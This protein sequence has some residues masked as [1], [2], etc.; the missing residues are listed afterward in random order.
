MFAPAGIAGLLTAFEGGEPFVVHG[1][2]ARF[3]P[4]L[5]ESPLRS[6]EDVCAAYRGR[7]LHGRREGG[8]RFHL[9]ERGAPAELLAGGEALYLPDIADVVPAAS[10]WLRELEL[11][12]GIPSG[13][14]RATAWVAPAGE[15]TAL[16]FDAEDV[17]SIQLSGSKRFE[18]GEPVALGNAASYQFGPGIPAAADLYPQ[19]AAGFPDAAAA[20]FTTLAMQPGS[21][22][23]L[24]RGHWHR[25]HC[26]TPSLSISVV[27]SPP[28]L[29][30]W[31]LGVLR[32][33]ALE[34]PRWRAPL[35]GAPQ[36]AEKVAMAKKA[37]R[38]LRIS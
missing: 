10:S 8:A 19:C 24:P 16:H 38:K 3:P 21:V 37:F 33:W 34:A 18:V 11:S 13:C 29:M 36:D 26:E 6:V 27:L 12:L 7:I 14:A 15:G 31:A 4:W 1:D 35:Y 23:A 9:L 20:R 22:L 32:H 30:D 28:L 17:I 5:R 25:T 2:P